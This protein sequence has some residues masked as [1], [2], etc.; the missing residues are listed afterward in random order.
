LGALLGATLGHGFDRGLSDLERLGP[1]PGNTER[2]QTAFFTAAFS[3]MGHL[4]KV[5]GRV[6]EDE[7]A[8]ARNVMAQMQLSGEQRETA[9]RLFREGKR[10]EFDL[11]AVLGQFRQE[12]HRRRHLIQM[13][14]E[15]QIAT[16]LSDGTLSDAE[17][18]LLLHM[19]D[20]LGFPQSGFE[21]LV[22][23]ALG[24]QNGGW[25]H[26]GGTERVTTPS[27]RRLTEDYVLLGVSENA[28]EAEV[29]KAYRR[30]MAQHH[31]DKLVAKG[32][33]EEMIKLATERTQNIKAA[34]ERVKAARA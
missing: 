29:K 32:L 12:C 17:R 21:Q 1:N 14:L 19:C 33:P 24:F 6:T 2:I 23:L 27:P 15:I 22:A 3:V 34:Y 31:P 9:I 20:C 13:F 18:N 26:H 11:D 16:A 8:T 5:D 4:A 25:S 7:I 10:G 30:L 28:S